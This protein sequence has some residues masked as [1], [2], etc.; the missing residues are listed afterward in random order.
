MKKK[1]KFSIFDLIVIGLS[2]AALIGLVLILMYARQEETDKK[3]ELENISQEYEKDSSQNTSAQ[4]SRELVINEVNQAGWVEIYNMGKESRNIKGVTIWLS[5]EEKSKVSEEIRLASKA[6]YI[7]EL[8]ETLNS[9]EQ[10]VLTLQDVKGQNIQSLLLPVLQDDESYGCVEDGSSERS[11]MTAS[12]E[13]TNQESEMAARGELVFSVPGGFYN[14]AFKLKLEAPEGYKIYY[15]TDGTQPTIKSAVYTEPIP[16][17]N[18]SGSNYNYVCADSLWFTDYTPSTVKMG[19]VV[20]AIAV[21]EDGTITQQKSESYYV[22]IGQSS[23]IMNLPILSLTTDPENLFDYFEGMY[24]SGRSYEDAI[25]RG[26]KDAIKANY[27]N[28]WRKS[29][30]LEYFEPNQDKTYEG[31][32]ELSMLVD[33]SIEEVQKGFLAQGTGAYEGSSLEKYYNGVSAQ[34][35]IQT[36]KRDNSYKVREYLI[37]EL[38]KDRAAGIWDISP[39]ILFIDGEYWG[40]YMLKSNYDEKYIAGRYQVTQEEMVFVKNGFA[41]KSQYQALYDEFYDFVVSEDMSLQKNYEQLQMQMDVQSYLDY[42]CANMFLANADYGLEEATAW[43][44]L[45]EKEGEYTDGKWRFLLGKMDYTIANRT[46]KGASSSSIDTYLQP[47]VTDDP[48]LQSLLKNDEFKSRLSATMSDMVQNVFTEQKAKTAMKTTSAMCSKMA[49]SSYERFIG[50]TDDRFF[51]NEEERILDFFEKRGEY[52]L[53]YT[54][55]L[56]K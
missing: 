9:L 18:R 40:G 44:T 6:V 45:A 33:Y 41:D 52:I 35:Q 3:L 39:C 22:E 36:N 4:A 2:A 53:K 10:S 21:S 54:D 30:H 12:K 1:R 24:V 50:Y 47:G 25:A 38:F 11:F 26:E 29:A 34:L 15:T 23:D 17:T 31:D 20:R 48:F 13:R 37:S 19:T 43:K 42:F 32:V 27:R 55:E 28:K 51:K 49:V 16:I 7:I 5:G 56:I 8:K 46:A 14:S